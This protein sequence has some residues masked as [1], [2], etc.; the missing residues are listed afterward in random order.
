MQG[1]L[2]YYRTT[3][4]RYDEEKGESRKPII[5]CPVP[6]RIISHLAAKLPTNLPDDLP[7][8][9]IWGTADGTAVRSVINR[10]RK[11]IKHY[12]DIALEGRSHWL[13]VE[14]KDDVTENV[15]QWLDRL[16]R[17]GPQCRAKL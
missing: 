13:M 5:H 12:H 4:I 7:V 14:A 17:F 2:N 9:F 3:K 16:T 8:L 6:P 15:A 1:P 11:F 10:A